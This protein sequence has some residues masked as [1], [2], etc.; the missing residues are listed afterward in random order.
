MTHMGSWSS[1]EQITTLSK[2]KDL[3]AKLTSQ[4]YGGEFKLLLKLLL[5]IKNLCNLS[6]YVN[7]QQTAISY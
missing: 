3:T 7:K 6:E 4:S 5:A 1:P 2:M